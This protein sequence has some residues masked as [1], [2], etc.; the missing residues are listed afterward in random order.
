MCHSHI[1]HQA[2]EF[3]HNFSATL[4]VNHTLL[5][6]RLQLALQPAAI[7]LAAAE[8]AIDRRRAAEAARAAR[9]QPPT[10]RPGD[11]V[12]GERSC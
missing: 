1:L 6:A 4:A 11:V 8:A 3:S 7:F 5:S 9:K 2:G 12:P 10:L